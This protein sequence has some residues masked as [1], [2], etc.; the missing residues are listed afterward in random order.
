MRLR[1]HSPEELSFYSKGTTDIEF[2]FPFGWGELWG[3]A[4]RT[5]YD[6]N[7][8]VNALFKLPGTESKVAGGNLVAEGFPDLADPE[9]NLLSGSP[10]YILEIHEDALGC[11]RPKVYHVFSVL[12]I[13]VPK[14]GLRRRRAST[15]G[16]R[17]RW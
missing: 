10:L 14:K 8:H 5:D 3:I 7:R 17:S 2:L 4:D 6:L 9:R 13:S 1:D 16:V 12:R 15:P 11:L